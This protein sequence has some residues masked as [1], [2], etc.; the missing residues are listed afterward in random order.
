VTARSL[1]TSASPPSTPTSVRPPLLHPLMHA[2]PAPHRQHLLPLPLPLPRLSRVQLL[3]PALPLRELIASQTVRRC[4]HTS[5]GFSGRWS[6]ARAMPPSS[7]L[8][9]AA[10]SSWTS[11][12]FWLTS[13]KAFNH[14]PA[15]FVLCVW[16]HHEGILVCVLCMPS[17]SHT[18]THT[19]THT[20]SHS[21][22]LS[23]YLL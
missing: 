7:V 23:F 16:S 11:C 13:P 2:P 9:S 6:T 12:S 19:L 15:R 17:H 21:L 1:S 18:F 22:P 3:A 8:S 5:I 14:K 10:L 4:E 20:H